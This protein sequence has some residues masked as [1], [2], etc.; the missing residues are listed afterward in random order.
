MSAYISGAGGNAKVRI[1]GSGVTTG[2][3][4]VNTPQTNVVQ[5]YTEIDLNSSQQ[6]DYLV[7]TG[8]VQLTILSHGYYDQVL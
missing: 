7:T 8:S 2:R 3:Q 5:T 6:F 1:T 4:I